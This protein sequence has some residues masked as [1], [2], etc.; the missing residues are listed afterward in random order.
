MTATTAT[1]LTSAGRTAS[2]SPSGSTSSQGDG[3]CA[4]SRRSTESVVIL[5]YRIARQLRQEQDNQR[6]VREVKHEVRVVHDPVSQEGDPR[7]R[8]ATGDRTTDGRITSQH[9]CQPHKA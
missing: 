4:A 8:G 5:T 2:A 3:G 7:R 1:P 6:R 9:W